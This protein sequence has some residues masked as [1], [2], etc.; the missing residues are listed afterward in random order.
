MLVEWDYHLLVSEEEVRA[1]EVAVSTLQ[2][3]QTLA[4]Q[5]VRY[6]PIWPS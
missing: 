6:D 1:A 5:V 3:P 4:K 2:P